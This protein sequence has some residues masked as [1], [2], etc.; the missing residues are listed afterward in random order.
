MITFLTICR[1]REDYL[2]DNSVINLF[3]VLDNASENIPKK[4]HNQIEFLIKFDDDDKVANERV[5]ELKEYPFVV[6]PYFYGR[7]EGLQ[8][9]HLH[10]AYLFTKRNTKYRFVGTLADDSIFMKDYVGEMFETMEKSNE[11]TIISG[12]NRVNQQ[13]D[14]AKDYRQAISVWAC[15]MEYSFPIVSS[16]IYEICGGMGWQLN[17]CNFVTLLGVILY[18]KYSINIF[19]GINSFIV[20]KNRILHD[21]FDISNSFN[22]EM[23]I[24]NNFTDC[25]SYYFDLVEQQA[26]NIYLN[27]KANGKI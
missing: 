12:N 24:D 6:K 11:Y 18:S 17:T 14:S 1:F 25:N 22:R 2:N 16:K 13:I 3:S 5:G 19:K 20:R 7:W 23:R 4:Y 26:R 21:T 8:T 27:M 9:A 15:G 10:F